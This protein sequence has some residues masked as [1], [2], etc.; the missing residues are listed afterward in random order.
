MNTN[1]QLLKT[2]AIAAALLVMIAIGLL[3]LRGEAEAPPPPELRNALYPE[4]RGLGEFTLIGSDGEPFGPANLEG[5]WSLMFFGYTHCPDICPT[6]LLTLNQFYQGLEA[7]PEA[8]ANTRIV[9]ISVDPKRDTPEH[10]NQYV[11]FFHKDFLAAT[12][13]RDQLDRLVEATGAVYMFE[14]DTSGDDYIV[15]HSAAISLVDPRG[16]LYGRFPPPHDAGE[17]VQTFLQI[18]RHY[19]DFSDSE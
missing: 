16:R 17:M 9:F 10:L 1:H 18:R 19:G 8:M 7:H 3:M 6:A 15:N 11:D 2:G 4:P 12:G 13:E 14:G 5:Q